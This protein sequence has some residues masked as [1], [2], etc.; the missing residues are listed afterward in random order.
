MQPMPA[1]VIADIEVQDPDSYMEY[2]AQVQATLDPFDGT[3]LVRGGNPEPLEGGWAP[4]RIVVIQ[5]PTAEQARG[6]YESPAYVK[7]M[8]IRDRAS[9]GSLILTHGPES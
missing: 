3:F 2:A 6:W 5:F 4:T 9:T 7:I 8:A 1:Y